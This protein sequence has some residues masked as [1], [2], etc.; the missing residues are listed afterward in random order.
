MLRKKQKNERITTR[1]S[2]VIAVDQPEPRL[3]HATS[4]ATAASCAYTL[5]TTQTTTDVDVVL[6]AGRFSN[7]PHLLFCQGLFRGSFRYL[8]LLLPNSASDP[9][10]ST[11]SPDHPCI[12]YR[13]EISFSHSWFVTALK[14]GVEKPSE[15]TL[16]PRYF[17]NFCH[18]GGHANPCI[19]FF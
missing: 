19:L 1:T 6:H 12:T 14:N 7:S 17:H 5:C 10:T 8:F 2:H 15:A 18:F 16:R 4:L 11:S 13:N 3:N 9:I